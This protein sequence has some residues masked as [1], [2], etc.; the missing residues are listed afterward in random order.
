MDKRLIFR[1]RS[2]TVKSYVCAGRATRS[3]VLELL[4]LTVQLS[5]GF[6]GDD[7]AGESR[8]A[9]LPT[10]ASKKSKPGDGLAPVPQTDTG[11]RA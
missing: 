7:E 5:S 4:R 9:I 6:L 2:W 1:Y 3:V 8:K 11:G 10:L